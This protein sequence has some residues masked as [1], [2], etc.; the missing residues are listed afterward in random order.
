[1][2]A[3][4]RPGVVRVD[5]RDSAGGHGGRQLG[6]FS[7]GLPTAVYSFVPSHSSLLGNFLFGGFTAILSTPCTAPMFVGI[8]VWAAQQPSWVGIATVM[9]V[10]LGMAAPYLILA[11]FPELARKLPR[12]GAWSELLKQFM[13]FLLLAVAAYFAAGRLI[14][15]NGYLWVVFAVVAA[16]GVFLIVRTAMLSKTPRAI[17]IASA[18]ALVLAGSVLWFT[19]KL[20]GGNHDLIPWQTYSAQTFESAVKNGQVVMVEFTA[21]WCANCK[22]LESRVFTDPKAAEAI[23]RLG[24]TP[25][26]ADLTTED[27]A[28]LAETPDDQCFGGNTADGDLFAEASRADPA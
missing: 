2:G 7:V 18:I 5:H 17:G 14:A 11:G 12:A 22:E 26:R 23:K 1:M 10:G 6:A 20:T 25:I 15:G 13:A 8:L 3:T 24:V 19:L 4:L 28:G 16:G 21:N 9:D 27:A